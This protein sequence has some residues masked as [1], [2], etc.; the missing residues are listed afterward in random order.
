MTGQSS[1]GDVYLHLRKKGKF[2]ETKRTE[3]CGAGPVASG[4]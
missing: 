2:L 3:V 4:G 1:D